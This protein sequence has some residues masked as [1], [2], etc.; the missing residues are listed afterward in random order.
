MPNCPLAA[1]GPSL[2]SDLPSAVHTAEQVRAMDRHAIEQL[3]IPAYTLMMRAGVAALRVLREY[4]PNAQRLLILCGPGNNAGDGYVLAR[5]A[6][7][8]GMQVHVVALSAP[9]Q[10]K[11]EALQAWQDFTAAGGMQHS[12]EP[13]CLEHAEVVVDA[14]FGTGLSRPLREEFAAPVRALNASGLPV[15]A[16]DIPS[17]LHADDGR[18][19]G[20]AVRAECTLSFVGLKLGYYLGEGPDYLGQLHFDALGVSRTPVTAAVARRIDIADLAQQLPPR[21]RSAHKGHHGHVL[22]VG[23]GPG[24][25]GAVRLAGEA[26]L[27][28]GAGLVTVATSAANVMAINAAR[29]ELMCHGVD[30]AAALERLMMRAEVIAIG[31][32][33][34][35]DSWAGALLEKILT[36]EGLLVLDADALNLLAQQPRWRSDW[37]LTPHPAEA[38]RLL[39]ISTEQV[40]NDRLRS[41]Q[42]LS[43]RYGGTVVLKG[44]NSVVFEVGEVP[45]LCDRGNPGMATAGMGDVLT[46]V[47]AGIAAQ[48]AEPKAAARLGV[49]AHALAGDLAAAEL[50]QRG[51]LAGD[52]IQRLPACVNLPCR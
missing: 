30:T 31:P 20:C 43:E 33:L 52:V 18:V 1:P 3:H 48:L 42:A 27:R 26:A 8:Q 5:M 16:L 21:R 44:A 45:W 7:A 2:R 39:G 40:Q 49:M 50:G 9:E 23:G 11:C 51:L 38:S 19:L 22:V 13:Q 37:I 47:V 25:G 35:T 14:I 34:G 28:V 12:W 4:W 6:R 46:G 32:G 36:W 15:L 17:G 41:A 24:M 29:P 10:L